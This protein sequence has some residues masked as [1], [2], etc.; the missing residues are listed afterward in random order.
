M[1]VR[2]QVGRLLTRSFG[3]TAA[4]L[5]FLLAGLLTTTS[6][7]A[8]Q[9][10]P[11]ERWRTLETERFRVTFPEGLDAVAERAAVHSEEAHRSLQEV[12]VEAPG[13][14]IDVLLTDHADYAQGFARI[15]PSNQI[16]IFLPPPVD[17][18]ALSHF[19]EWLRLVIVHELAHVF[20]MDRTGTLGRVGRALVG[21]L[22]VGWPLFPNVNQPRWALEGIA[23][24]Y[25]TVLTGEGGRGHGTYHEMMLRTAALEG[26]LERLDQALGSSPVWPAGERPYLYGS[27]FF[28]FMAERYGEEGVGE[29]SEA[30]VHQWV[31]FRLN[32]A[33]NDGFGVTFNE[34]WEEWRESLVE[35]SAAHVAALE[36]AA[37]LTTP[38][39]L[40]GYGRSTLHPAAGF[41]GDSLVY[42]R[43]D[44]HSDPQ[45]RLLAL[46]GSGD[47]SLFRVNGATTVSRHPSGRLL[48]SQLE[49]TDAYRLRGDLYLAGLDGSVERVTT[50]ERLSHGD[51][52]PGGALAA[53]VQ[54]GEGT[55]RLVIVDLE[56]GE[57]R[58]LTPW[59]RERH[60]AYPRWSP[61]G[62]WIAASLWS[63]EESV[64]HIALL[65]GEGGALRHLLPGARFVDTSPAWSPDGSWLVWASDRTGISNL[66]A[67]PIDSESGEPG[68]VRQLT[69][70]IGGALFP[71]VDPDGRWIVFSSYG[72]EG[73][74]LARVPFGP[75][76]GFAPL[77]AGL[78]GEAA[79]GSGAEA[80]EGDRSPGD[81]GG[82]R[83]AESEG[84]QTIGPSRRYSPL[85]TLLPRYWEP[86]LQG[87]ST[88]GGVEVVAPAFG[89]RTSGHDLVGRHRY[90]AEVLRGGAPAGPQWWAWGG[91]EW[92]GLGN[93]GL[94]LSAEQEHRALSALSVP[95]EVD[96]DADFVYP[97]ARERSVVLSSTFLHRRFRRAG[98]V[99]VS[100]RRLSQEITL[101]DER[102]M[103][104]ELAL[105]R[106]NRSFLEGRITASA[107][108]A[109]RHAFSV[110]REEGVS[111]SLRLRTRHEQSVPDTLRGQR[112]G[113]GRF[114]DAVAVVHAFRGFEGPGYANH[115]LA[116]R[117]AAGAGTGPGA[118]VGHFRVGGASG[119][120]DPLLGGVLGAGGSYLFAVRGQLSGV[121]TG[122]QAWAASLEYRVPIA[123]LH[124]GWRTFPFYL[125][126]LSGGVFVDAAGTRGPDGH[127]GPRTGTVASAGA[128]LVLEALPFWF[129]PVPLRAGVA[130]PLDG[131]TGPSLHFRIG[132]SF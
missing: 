63:G 100:G 107:S 66:F 35:E 121:R 68:E 127:E 61:D 64:F 59:D 124:R 38:K 3:R 23:T 125:D 26:Q 34:A 49:F 126:R 117:V 42:F 62:R 120:S 27:R 105:A 2:C 104:S 22:P 20:H 74:D 11:D 53:A 75:L 87:G 1:H 41:P 111:A 98:R 88:T 36:A 13:R 97:V 39:A 58:P 33:A 79:D 94:G 86:R 65:D 108:T 50:G 28:A 8:A 17:G 122:S 81:L 96:S 46:D 10:A 21:R 40:T 71:T 69:N 12:F 128:E 72:A 37:P 130:V 132:R 47:R 95:G 57:V 29:Y 44:G 89:G 7:A 55:N 32:S 123:V 110:G 101:R 6:P 5:L 91:Y 51:V 54:E 78:G 9:G 106:P 43:S 115:V 45:L 4:I 76:D 24:Y 52:H 85:P 70:L 119:G 80:Q 114:D 109:R 31:P 84:E 56:S 73:W 103:P 67:V 112:G 131:A 15:F 14:R 30:V 92:W 102:G 16:V 99:E 18:F 19:D 48:F 25:E 113:D 82:D 60:W 129:S 118:G 93:P 77:H 83:D 90:A 116:L